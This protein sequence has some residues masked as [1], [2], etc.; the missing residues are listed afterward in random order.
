MTYR[1]GSKAPALNGRGYDAENTKIDIALLTISVIATLYRW[2]E[3]I[4][5]ELYKAA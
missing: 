2:D 4:I 1:P 3:K 5:N